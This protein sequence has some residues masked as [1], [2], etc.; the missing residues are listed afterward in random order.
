MADATDSANTTASTEPPKSNSKTSLSDAF[1]EHFSGD[2]PL[3]DKVKSFA[4]AKPWASAALAGIAGI[5]I[6]NTFRGN[7]R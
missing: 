3:G 5:A 7:R 1:R 6:L 4:K 2:A